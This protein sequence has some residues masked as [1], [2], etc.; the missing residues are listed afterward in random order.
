MSFRIFQLGKLGRC[1]FQS[2]V[3]L[4]YYKL[5][6]LAFFKN[7]TFLVFLTIMNATLIGMSHPQL[8]RKLGRTE[9]QK[10]YSIVLV[11]YE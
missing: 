5:A 1:M 6:S 4:G 11:Q 10:I 9:I 2:S 3:G 7:E 8:S